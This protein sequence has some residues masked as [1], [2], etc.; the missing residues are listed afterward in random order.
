MYCHSCWFNTYWIFSPSLHTSIGILHLK[1]NHNNHSIYFFLRFSPS[2]FNCSSFISINCFKLEIIFKL[3]LLQFFSSLKFGICYLY[4]FFCLRW[5]SK[6]IF[7]CNFTLH[8][9]VPYQVWSS[10]FWLLC[11]LFGIYIYITILSFS[12]KFVRN[13]A[14]LLNLICDFTSCKFRILT[15]V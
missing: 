7:C 8:N 15:S 2:Y 11:F 3:T 12:I 14:S 10:F 1:R 13:W 9:F 6:L 5:F 4:S